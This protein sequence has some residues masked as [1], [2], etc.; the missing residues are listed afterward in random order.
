[1]NQAI[2][3]IDLKLEDTALI[4]RVALMAKRVKS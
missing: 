1:M 2:N 4:E 3:I